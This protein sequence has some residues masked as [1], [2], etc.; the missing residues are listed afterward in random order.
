MMDVLLFLGGKRVAGNP[1][2][3]DLVQEVPRK[4][5][6]PEKPLEIKD[7][8]GKEANDLIEVPDNYLLVRYIDEEGIVQTQIRRKDSSTGE[9]LFVD[10]DGYIRN[11]KDAAQWKR[12]N[13]VGST[14]KKHPKQAKPLYNEWSWRE[15]S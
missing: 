5:L 14:P 4:E 3:S 1:T 13:T 11:K 15:K 12:S 7:I 8:L 9:F 2:G 10:D 6:F